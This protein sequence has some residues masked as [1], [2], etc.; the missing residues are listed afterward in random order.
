MTVWSHLSTIF[1]RRLLLRSAAI[2]T[3][4][5]ALF[6]TLFFVATTHAENGINKT[7]SFQG[8]LLDS[9]GDVVPDGYY[10]VQ[11]KI[12]QG[13]SGSAAGD[14]DGTLKWTETYTNNGGNNGVQ[15]KNGFM[16]VNL[17]SQ[18]PFGNSIDW[19][20]D[21][22]WLSMN[23]A[24]KST[25]CSTFGTSPCTADGE[26]LPMKQLTASPYALNSGAINGL[27]SGQL[28]QLG[29]GAQTDATNNSSIYINK[30]G[31]GSLLQ[32]QNN[33][34]DVL[35]IA[36]NGDLLFGANGNHSI[37][38]ATSATGVAGINLTLAAGGGGGGSGSAGGDLILS[39]G[40]GGGTKG[41]GGNISLDA[42]AATGTGS[43]GTIAIGSTNAGTITIGSTTD[44][45]TQNITIGNN[46][47]GTANVTIGS[48]NTATGGSTTIQGKDGVTIAANG[49]TG[50]TLSGTSNTAY[51]GNGTES[52][53]P[54]NYTIQGTN[55]SADG[56]H[57]GSLSISG[58]NA[59]T[60]DANGGNIVLTGGTGSGTGT[61]GN[62]QI[63][64]TGD[65]NVTL[66]TLDT[67]SGAPGVSDPA[68]IGSMY[69]DTTLGELQCYN[70]DGWGNCTDSPDAFVSMSPEYNNAVMHG[71]GIGT[72]TTDLCSDALNF[73]DGSDSQ[74]TIC[75]TNETYNFYHWTSSE[76]TAQT[77][78]IYVTY[79]LPDNFKE[80]VSGS[81]SL[82][83]RTDSSDASVNYQVYH[84]N[85]TTGL[86][87]C[88]SPVSVAADAETSWQQG[89]ATSTADPSTCSFTAGDSVVFKIDLTSAN[90]ANAYV[91]NL[92][93]TYSTH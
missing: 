80:F 2:L 51:F 79:K 87:A 53:T 71:D 45:G 37:G 46:G 8:R 92:A 58:G 49:T 52:P 10:N 22:L 73:N 7:I 4:C 15:V 42:G 12:Y 6:T 64:S 11:F 77:R 72:M 93:F 57:G 39:G 50:I 3:L 65:S 59:T 19:N 21:T 5:V 34:V 48:T 30:T 78:S 91:S 18:N 13:G 62:V 54:G 14:P 83:A 61:S 55:S 60:G 1:N 41:A 66:L 56:A 36:N 38:A 67:A 88:G 20:Q 25:S 70:T 32:L 75:G 44:A 40:S 68:L 85:A 33:A 43:R 74:P 24:G 84:N 17:G 16:S 47:T 76:L 26:M 23:I 89:T 27:T 63:G 29:Q 69:Y 9:N 81:T 28:V 86:T 90:D 35:N 82:T 31:T